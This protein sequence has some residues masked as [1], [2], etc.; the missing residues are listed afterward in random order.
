MAGE[1][2]VTL[3]DNQ[4]WEATQGDANSLLPAPLLASRVAVIYADSLL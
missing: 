4:F 2:E 3:I 1:N